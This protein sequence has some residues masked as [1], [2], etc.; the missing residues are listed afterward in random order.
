LKAK[1][2]EEF[3]RKI[4]ELTK[5]IDVFN[6]S[7]PISLGE[8]LGFLF[9]G[10]E[11]TKIH[12]NKKAS[13]IFSIEDSD[14]GKISD[15]KYFDL[16]TQLITQEISKET[17]AKNKQTLYKKRVI[18]F[19][20][21][22]SY[23]LAMAKSLG[24]LGID[25]NSE[26]I[27]SDELSLGMRTLKIKGDFPYQLF[28]G[29]K[30][31]PYS[32]IYELLADENPEIKAKPNE[33]IFIE[34]G[35]PNKRKILYANEKHQ[36][37]EHVPEEA[38]VMGLTT[39]NVQQ[40]CL[41]YALRNKHTKIAAIEGLPGGGKTLLAVAVGI[42]GVLANDGGYERLI[43]FSSAHPLDGRDLGFIP[44]SLEEK[45]QVFKKPLD[46]SI[47]CILK[48]L[49]EKDKSLHDKVE[50]LEKNK[51]ILFESIA[52]VRGDTFE[53]AFVICDE[54]QNLNPHE[55]KT[56]IS[57]IDD[58]TKIVLTGDINQIDYKKNLDSNTNGL[59]HVI[60]NLSQP[61][62]EEKEHIF[63]TL[64]LTIGERSYAATLADRK[65]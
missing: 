38:T 20:A 42:E 63:V 3:S 2:A 37:F 30:F 4:A 48:N 19:V 50:A 25:Y 28:E 56:L 54:T 39:R 7:K 26:K 18:K 53:Q 27:N 57:R 11:N 29:S 5:E 33:F 59:T 32:K 65:L 24:I 35:D 1:A 55:S 21:R 10:G 40:A 46:K 58:D 64:K 47:R 61:D 22:N 9:I 16:C 62:P 45:L 49:K 8:G 43:F 12:N 34:N 52:Y 23:L 41:V 31:V 51:K 6:N 60:Y 13:T 15:Y 14:E 17:Q 36:R 44:G